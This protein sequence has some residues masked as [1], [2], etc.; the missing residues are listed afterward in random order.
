MMLRKPG[1]APGRI[2]PLLVSSLPAPRLSV[3]L[4]LMMPLAALVKLL[5]LVLKV[6]PAPISMVPALLG[7]IVA[8]PVVNVPP[9]CALSV[10]LLVSGPVELMVIVLPDASALIT[11]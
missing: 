7:N 1:D 2:V 9:F 5:L 6:E 10:P 11:P 4:P 3:P 8:L